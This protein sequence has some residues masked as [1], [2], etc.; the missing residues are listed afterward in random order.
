[1]SDREIFAR[2]TIVVGLTII[3]ID[4]GHPGLDPLGRS[5]WPIG[6]IGSI[7]GLVVLVR[8]RARG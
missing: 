8:E 3:A 2:L 5:L 7:A 1:V 4:V 6:V